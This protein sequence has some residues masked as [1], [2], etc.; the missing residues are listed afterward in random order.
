MLAR[1][2]FWSTLNYTYLHRMVQ[3]AGQS[4][5]KFRDAAAPAPISCAT[6]LSAALESSEPAT[7]CT[8]VVCGS[9][10]ALTNRRHHWLLAVGTS[11]PASLLD[12]VGVVGQSCF[13][14]FLPVSSACR[15]NE[16]FTSTHGQDPLYKMDRERVSSPTRLER[17]SEPFPSPSPVILSSAFLSPRLI[18]MLLATSE[19]RTAGN[20]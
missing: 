6:F 5:E 2:R 20:I 11:T 1:G 19:N 15:R 12:S 17:R 4:V 16:S 3:N 9:E 10:S 8:M 14:Q 18:S 13:K 7:L